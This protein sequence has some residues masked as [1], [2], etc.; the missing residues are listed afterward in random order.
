MLSDTFISRPRLAAVI[1]IV[2]TLAGLIA[3]RALPIAQ[4]P[5]IVPPQV[6][7]SAF[8]PGA[9][10][11]V[12]ETTVAQPIESQV[13]G[14]DDMLYMK[15]TSGSDG[16][17]NLTVT[18][19][20]GT[21]P[22]IA[23][24]NV[25]N[26][27]SLATAGLPSEVTATGVSVQ[28]Q[29]SALLQVFALSSDDPA[30]DGLF[31]SNYATINLLDSFKRVPGVGNAMLFGA[32]D[33]SMRMI[34]DVD[35]MTSLDLGP[36]DIVEALRA[37]NVQAAIGRIG[38][39]PMTDDPLFQLN[40]TTQGRLT[41]ASQFGD[42]VLR[43]NPDG[44]FVRIR[45]VARV[46]LGAQNSDVS[47]QLN[48]KPTAMI[49]IYQQ[50]GA[51]ALSAGQGVEATLER[52]EANFPPGMKVTTVYDTTAFVK[53][54][55]EEVVKTL[56]EAFV[57]VIIVVF[58]FLG[59]ARA[60][61]IPLIAVPV[62]LIGTFAV[63]LALGFS[64]NTVSLLAMVL[65]IGIVVDD[66][67]VVVENVERVMEENPGMSAR[68]A[69][70]EAM[71]EITGAI[72]AI[73][74]VLLS[75]FV[76][77]AFIP[78]L[79]G[80]LFQQFAVAV[81]VSMVISAINALTLSP[82]LCA[83]LLKPT[84]GPKR[85]PLG[86]ISRRIDNAR[87]GY[88][89]VAG[90]I[91]RR[92]ILA[93][94][95]LAVF[96]L[97]AGALFRV[98]PSGFLP[99]EDQGA[100]FVEMRTPQG[101]SV[102]RTAAAVKDVEAMLEGIEGVENVVT[103]TGYSF[104]DGLAASNSAFAIVGLKPF[105]ERTTR[106]ASVFAAIRT[107]LTKGLAIREAQVFAFN[108]PPIIGLGTGSGFEYQLLDLQG[109][110]PADL[111]S[112]A[113]AI[114]VAANEDPRLGPTFTTFSASSPQLY[115]DLDRERLMTLGVSVRDLFTALQGTLGQI[116]VNDFNLYGRTWQVNV[117]ARQSDR[118]SVSDIGRI[119]VRSN[120]GQMVPIAAVATVKY[121]VG[122][123]SIVR[124][125]NYRSVTINGSPA[126]NVASGVA[127]Q[128]MEE[129]SAKVLP[130]G[131]SYTWTGT[132]Q[133]EL[134]AAGQTT[135][136]LILAILF[137]YLF[138]VGL[139]ESWTIPVP[140]L[141]SVSVGVCGALIALKLGGIAFG[142]YAQIGLVVLIALAAKNAILIVEFAKAGRE[143][144][145]SILD[146]ALEGARMRFRA[147]LMTS[148]AFIAGL[149]PLVIATGAA[150]FSRRAV[151]TGVA[152]GMLASAVIGIFLIPALYVVFQRLREWVKGEGS[153]PAK[154]DG[155]QD[156]GPTA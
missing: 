14:V 53:A 96:I 155:G 43:A 55:V 2:L 132:A 79:S 146:A 142:I 58:L 102:N 104:L 10:A 88:V 32:L 136:I 69:A 138:L 56:I 71:G 119:N 13:N 148:F 64:L 47:A 151:G 112:V 100:F 34:L 67:I 95:L 41:D 30:Q 68:D 72:V 93:I 89:K 144:G 81:S 143:S 131:Y 22:D 111:A 149:I 28:K 84:H 17:Y 133:Q 54:S 123:Q 52:L 51:N 40:L 94:A 124:Y 107:A 36:G 37:Q 105:E 87:D 99:I 141:L 26:R 114:S 150:M 50:P 129:I 91:A 122:P 145:L 75:V 108:L 23:T 77:V 78:G 8:Y 48:G 76:P 106:S 45:D 25:Q 38:A 12:V 90:M 16:S 135:T 60:T 92:A 1:S 97:G 110:T 73:T 63:M 125:N 113:G 35:R 98:V 11:D 116:Y 140:V 126:P 85:G 29:S 139:Y 31:L 134:E 153:A 128:A 127:L 154:A 156:T 39:Q 61:M 118:A 130:Q 49:G 21:D 9:G 101:S 44:S 66:A 46:E 65:A 18:F 70:H 27:V 82:A 15:S 6:V 117:Q 3:L 109:S 120:T 7:V 83:V 24:V 62:A 59:N 137:A 4:Y 103:V 121:I 20:V 57:L 19:A 33:Y 5:D 42:V 74:L 152:G 80:Q 147:I 86:W 115:L